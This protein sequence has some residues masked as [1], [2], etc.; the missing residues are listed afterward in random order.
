MASDRFETAKAEAMAG[1]LDPG[2]N[3]LN[4][5]QAVLRCCLVAT[6]QD[7][8]L[9]KA[10][11]Y[12]GGGMVRMGQVCGAL[13]GAAVALG[14]CADAAT[15]GSEKA[16]V[17]PFDW[18][19]ELIRKFE[20]EFGAIT[21]RDLLGCDI[22]TPEGFRAAKKSQATKRCPEFVSWTCDRM[23]EILDAGTEE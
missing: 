19:Q 1:Y 2:P 17:T 18:L 10:A 11:S 5:G 23:G 3:H 22:S 12:L 16:G 20:A 21:C 4:C 6:G 8:E 14:L 7:R 13:S 9:T 15:G